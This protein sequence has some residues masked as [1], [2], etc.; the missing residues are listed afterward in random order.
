MLGSGKKMAEGGYHGYDLRYFADSQ[1]F[2]DYDKK[3]FF[4]FDPRFDSLTTVAISRV[5]LTGTKKDKTEDTRDVTVLTRSS[6]KDGHAE[7]QTV[8]KIRQ[9][10]EEL[11]A[12]G[13]KIKTLTL[14]MNI[15]YSPCNDADNNCQN[16]LQLFFESLSCKTTFV[17]RFAYLYHK[18][19]VTGDKKPIEQLANWMIGL[20]GV[21]GMR[22]ESIEVSKELSSYSHCDQTKWEEVKKKREQEDRDM[23]EKIKQ[24]YTRKRE[25]EEENRRRDEAAA[26]SL[27]ATLRIE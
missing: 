1:I 10:I 9:I 22:V 5:Q 14:V 23:K 15:T 16:V 11:E 6:K 7:K 13:T 8:G 17:L 18:K 2:H 12:S 24:V 4:Q 21:C 20:E 26:T 27:H 25:I 19:G 3:R